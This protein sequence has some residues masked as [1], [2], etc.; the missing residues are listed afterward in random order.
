MPERRTGGDGK[1]KIK[2]KMGKAKKPKGFKSHL[3]PSKRRV[4]ED[5]IQGA[6]DM[7]DEGRDDDGD[8][9][10]N[11]TFERGAVHASGHSTNFLLHLDERSVSK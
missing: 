3:E 2:V 9:D 7:L 4:D 6:K 10:Q 5:I 1:G 8:G 11:G